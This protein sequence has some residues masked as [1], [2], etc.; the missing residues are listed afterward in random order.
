M[1]VKIVRRKSLQNVHDQ[2]LACAS[3]VSQPGS[4]NSGR[5]GT[6]FHSKKFVKMA[7]KSS[8]T[9]RS[10]AAGLAGASAYC[11]AE[12]VHA[13]FLQKFLASQNK[14]A[15]PEK[16]APKRLW[17]TLPPTP[18]LP[19]TNRKWLSDLNG[20]SIFFAEYGQGPPI[21][22]LHGGLANSA[23]WGS[24]IEVLSRSHRVI[25]MDT[26]GH[27]RSPVRS[28]KF[29]YEI[30]A[31][32]VLALLNML[33]LPQVTVAGWSDGAVTGLQ[34]AMTKPEKVSGLFMFGG[35]VNVSGYRP[36]GSKSEVFTAYSKRCRAEYARLSPSPD[37]WNALVSGLTPMWRTQPNF[38]RKQLQAIKLP[39][40]ISAGAHDEII[41]RSHTEQMAKDIH[42]AKLII[43][44][45]VS[46]FAML[47]N[48]R[49]FNDALSS[50][51]NGIN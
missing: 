12:P 46:H 29:G 13:Q 47:Q 49:Q 33:K 38:S 1:N 28:G 22:L 30:F 26:R 16:L 34:L 51:L 32:D 35:N 40:V 45:G 36:N 20:T 48:P 21:L 17:Q 37:K 27:G 8:L 10:F 41:R 5:E 3:L 43:Q 44:P 23:Y 9:R 15:S 14:Q 42:G 11:L 50:F 18:S 25:A 4:R 24:Q 7:K 19:E 39:V 31:E 2:V 6:F